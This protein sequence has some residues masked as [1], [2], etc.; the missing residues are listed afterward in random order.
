MSK[1]TAVSSGAALRQLVAPDAWSKSGWACGHMLVSPVFPLKAAGRARQELFELYVYTMGDKAYAHAMAS[2]L[3]TS[4]T[5][6]KNR[7]VANS[8]VTHHGQKDLDVVMLRGAERLVVILDD[9]EPVWSANRAN[10]V[11]VRL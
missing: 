6:F 8:D 4:G 5:L 7:I 9:T 11:Q 2:L 3:D 10:L 1:R